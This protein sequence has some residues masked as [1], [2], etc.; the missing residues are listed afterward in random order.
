MFCNRCGAKNDEDAMFCQECGRKLGSVDYPAKVSKSAE[1]IKSIMVAVVLVALLAIIVIIL[2]VPSS[3]GGLSGL[4]EHNDEDY[5]K[6][7]SGNEVSI[8]DYGITFRGTYALEG[9]EIT[10]TFTVSFMGFKETETS[11]GTVSADR[12]EIV[13]EGTTYTKK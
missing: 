12:K 3:S 1:K 10:I 8:R 9:D 11:R 2:F 4:Y 6:F 5:L 7:T 13:L